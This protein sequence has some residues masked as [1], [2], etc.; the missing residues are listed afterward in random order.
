VLDP[1]DVPPDRFVV[2][3]GVRFHYLDWGGDGEDLLLLAGLGCTAHVF[4]ELA[5][6]LTDRFR[7]LALT[8]RGHGLTERVSSGYA[9]ADAAEDALRLLDELGVE[10]AHLVGHSMGGGEVSALAARHPERVG[11][12]VYLDGAYDWADGP[13]EEGSDAPTGPDWFA[14]YDDFARYVRSLSP[15]FEKI[16]GPAFDA[17]CRTLVDTHADGSVT[18]KHS[19]AE[20]A[21]FEQAVDAF[22]HPFAEITAP[23]LA[24]YAVGDRWQGEAAAWL[25]ASRD[26]FLAETAGG[27]VLEIDDASHYLFLDR[28]DEVLAAM[29]A[30]IGGGTVSIP[31]PADRQ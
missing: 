21:P 12:V 28:R 29:R 15:D 19:P 18:E 20:M 24:I 4:V 13:A 7:V 23:A 3:D 9:L 10:R 6:H 17:M 5:P 31:P 22:R 1:V 25:A 30:F 8:R 14:S 16:W 26:R 2:L 11:S 27:Q